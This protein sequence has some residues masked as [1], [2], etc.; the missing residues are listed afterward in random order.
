MIDAWGVICSICK[1][2]YEGGL[3]VIG[4]SMLWGAWHL[5]RPGLALIRAALGTV[6]DFSAAITL[7]ATTMRSQA[8]QAETVEQIKIQVSEIHAKIVGTSPKN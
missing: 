3:L 8:V 5:G 6:A 2:V 1:A 7:A 4:L